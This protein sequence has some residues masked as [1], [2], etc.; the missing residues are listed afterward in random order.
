MIFFNLGPYTYKDFASIKDT[1]LKK[2]EIIKIE[3]ENNVYYQQ[4]CWLIDRLKY[5]DTEKTFLYSDCD[6]TGSDRYAHLAVWKSYSELLERWAYHDLM[7]R[8]SKEYG[9]IFDRTTTGFAALPCWPRYAARNHAL[10]EAIERWSISNWWRGNLSASL[11]D[12][13]N[14]ANVKTVTIDIS[15]KFGY[16]VI[17]YNSFNYQNENKYFYG[18]AHSFNREQAYLKSLVEMER[19]KLVIQNFLG[20]NFSLKSISDKRLHYFSTE[21]GYAKFLNRINNLSNCSISLP[22]LLIDCHIPGPWDKFA[23]VWR[24][25]YPDTIYNWND[26]THF[27]F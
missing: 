23:T 25:L 1:P 18:F 3:N 14:T 7:N 21:L 17:S 26:E 20:S 9:L 10:S 4:N 8:G 11:F 27:M 19:N 5:Q 6:A 13:K 15:K 2:S 16:V 24:C 22:K 12:Y